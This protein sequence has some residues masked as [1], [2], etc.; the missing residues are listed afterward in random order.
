MDRFPGRRQGPN[1]LIPEEETALFPLGSTGNG[2]RS[3]WHLGLLG[4]NFPA[5]WK[6]LSGM[7]AFERGESAS[8]RHGKTGN[9][10]VVRMRQEGQLRSPSDQSPCFACTPSCRWSR[11]C[12]TKS[13]RHHV[14]VHAGCSLE[15]GGCS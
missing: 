4:D 5:A 10:S 9:S 3:Q 12:S 8:S 14:L 2:G 11:G 7:Q 6:G 15:N 13:S 1:I